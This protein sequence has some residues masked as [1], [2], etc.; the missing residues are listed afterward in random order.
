MPPSYVFTP[1]NV[2]ALVR[3]A[4]PLAS[5]ISGSSSIIKLVSTVYYGKQE[6]KLKA[7]KVLKAYHRPIQQPRN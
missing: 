1:P 6:W 4:F 3:Y 7:L 5:S 2:Q